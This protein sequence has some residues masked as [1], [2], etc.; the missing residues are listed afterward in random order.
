MKKN[1]VILILAIAVGGWAS[2]QT[3]T[4]YTTTEQAPWQMKGKVKVKSLPLTGYSLQDNVN[5]QLSMV[6]S[7]YLNVTLAPHSFNTFVEK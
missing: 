3:F 4:Q 2:A 6:N 1:I 5:G 7:K